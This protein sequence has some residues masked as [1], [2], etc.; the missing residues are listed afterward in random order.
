MF[1]EVISVSPD[2]HQGG[3]TFVTFTAAGAELFA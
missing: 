3:W 2:R 1:G